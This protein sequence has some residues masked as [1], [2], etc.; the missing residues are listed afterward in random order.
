MRSR[1]RGVV[2]WLSSRAC[3]DDQQVHV[4]EDA[5]VQVHKSRHPHLRLN[6]TIEKL[7]TI[8][9]HVLLLFPRLNNTVRH[10]LL[11]VNGNGVFLASAVG[12]S[13]LNETLPL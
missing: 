11:H 2:P 10:V 9:R 13:P 4:D 5:A 12:L 7:S 3:W 6:N 1:S 8:R